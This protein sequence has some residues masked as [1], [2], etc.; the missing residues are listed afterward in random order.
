MAGKD[1]EVGTP[2]GVL[3]ALIGGVAV[4]AIAAVITIRR[5]RQISHKIPNM[6]NPNPTKTFVVQ[7]EKCGFQNS[8]NTRHCGN[9]G[10]SLRDDETQVYSN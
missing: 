3:A 9:C 10:S 1:P 7:C 8:S 2:V 5:K 4:A 6:P